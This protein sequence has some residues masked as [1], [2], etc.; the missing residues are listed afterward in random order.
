MNDSIL[1]KGAREHNLKNI[2][3]EIPRNKLVVFTGLSGSGK[4]SLAF[5]TLFAEGQRRY[6]ESLSSYARQF[7][8]QMEK[9]DVD[10]IEGLSPSISIDQKTTS[11]NP[12]STVGTIT[13]IYDYLRLMYA[14]IGKPHC[15]NCGKPI[16]ETTVDQICDS[17]M[18]NVDASVSILAPV[19][20]SRKGEYSKQLE[21]YKKQGFLRIRIDGEN[22]ML[23]EELPALDKQIKHTI[24]VIVDR[25]KIKEGLERR[26]SDS[27]E[28]A[29]KLAEGIMVAEINGVE[30]LFNTKYNCPD[31][32]ISLP[33]LTPRIFSFNS[34]FG[35]CPDCHGLGFKEEIDLDLMIPDWNKSLEQGAIDIAG[36]SFDCRTIKSQYNALSKHFGFSVNTPLKDLPKGIMEIILYGTKGEKIE[37]KYNS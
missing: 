14:S 3:V 6:M 26:L 1:I 32:D 23:D 36:A 5:D 34:P 7:L 28:L 31:C 13:E 25:L 10:Y 19:V 22:Y 11:K 24:S 21:G 27:V 15:P 33:E 2:N 12:R 37:V 20:R 18:S 8:G 35:A 4:S 16:E 30:H 29:L 17:I 9:P